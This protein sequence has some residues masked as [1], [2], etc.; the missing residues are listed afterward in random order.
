MEYDPATGEQRGAQLQGV[1]TG[2]V[3]ELAAV[4]YLRALSGSAS[5]VQSMLPKFEGDDLVLSMAETR[6]TGTGAADWP[7]P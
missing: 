3:H 2:A 7:L 4:A 6:T 1:H 5:A